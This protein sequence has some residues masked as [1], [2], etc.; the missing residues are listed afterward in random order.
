[1]LTLGEMSDRRRLLREIDRLR[2]LLVLILGGL[3]DYWVTT[4]DGACVVRWAGELT[5]GPDP[6][7][8]RLRGEAGL[9][10]PA[11]A[12]KPGKRGET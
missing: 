6:W 4:A 7:L 2:S 3:D 12:A 9:T 8:E 10:P 11:D 1:M 5:K